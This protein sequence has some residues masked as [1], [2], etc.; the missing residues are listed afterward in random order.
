MI[1]SDSTEVSPRVGPSDNWP[2][3]VIEVTNA[4]RPAWLIQPAVLESDFIT[5]DFAQAGVF[6]TDPHQWMHSARTTWNRLR[7]GYPDWQCRV[8]RL[9]EEYRAEQAKHA[10]P[11]LGAPS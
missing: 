1:L 5:F 11:R 4:G 7:C 2:Q 10:I 3:E 9:T 8:V 6:T